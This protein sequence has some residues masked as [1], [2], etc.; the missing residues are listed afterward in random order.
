MAHKFSII[1]SLFVALSF[2]ANPTNADDAKTISVI[3]HPG[4]L[5]IRVG[6]KTFATYVFR[7]DKTLRPYFAN[8][9][10][11]DSTQVTRNHPPQ[12]GDPADHAELH[13]GIWLAF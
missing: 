9:H 1:L 7:D 8:V 5:E 13:P 4:N 3:E 10:A 6:G 11:P 12:Q 2:Q